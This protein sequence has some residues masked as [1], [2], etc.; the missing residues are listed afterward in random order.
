M[1]EEMKELKCPICGETFKSKEE[2]AKHA[3]EKHKK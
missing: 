2:M 1:A 3:M